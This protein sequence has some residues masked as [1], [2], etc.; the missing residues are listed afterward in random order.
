MY[1]SVIDIYTPYIAFLVCIA[2]IPTLIMYVHTCT[3]MHTRVQQTNTHVHHDIQHVH[4]HDHHDT[5]VE[6]DICSTAYPS[7]QIIHVHG[8]CSIR[9]ACYTQLYTIL[10]TFSTFCTLLQKMCTFQHA[11]HSIITCIVYL[12]YL[13]HIHSIRHVYAQTCKNMHKVTSSTHIVTYRLYHMCIL[14]HM[15]NTMCILLCIAG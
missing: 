1:R 14:K 11:K 13:L 9:A 4:N 3:E 6:Y 2:T 12:L 8:T 7:I 5:H 10:H 15:Q